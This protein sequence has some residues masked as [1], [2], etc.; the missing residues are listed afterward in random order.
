MWLYNAVNVITPITDDNE[1]LY[2]RACMWLASLLNEEHSIKMKKLTSKS[3]VISEANIVSTVCNICKVLDGQIM[4]P[5]PQAFLNMYALSNTQNNVY[6][7]ARGIVKLS[8]LFNVTYCYYP[9]RIAEAGLYLA[10]L[11]LHCEPTNN[12]RNLALLLHKNIV[13][14]EDNVYLDEILAAV[15]DIG[16]IRLIEPIPNWGLPPFDTVYRSGLHS[17]SLS[18]LE[19]I[20]SD[21]VTIGNGCYGSVYK[22]KHLDRV[23]AIK[24]HVD[25]FN[26]AIV[27]LAAMRS[28][29]SPHIESVSNFHFENTTVYTEMELRKCTLKDLIYG[30]GNVCH[31]SRYKTVWIDRRNCKVP[32]LLPKKRRRNIASQLLHGLAHLKEHGVIHRDIKP[33]NILVTSTGQIKIADF[34]LSSLHCNTI[35]KYLCPHSA[36][37]LWWRDIRLLLDY[38]YSF[39]ADMWALGIVLL[40]METGANPLAGTTTAE[41]AVDRIEGLFG[42]Y[43]TTYLVTK[44]VEFIPDRKFAVLC[45]RMMH[46]SLVDRITPSTAIEE[47]V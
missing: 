29:S 42:T 19:T 26:V 33:N 45:K 1:T 44:G 9:F 22:V 31:Y 12:E 23:V 30:I 27:E 11:V 2:I 41:E 47:L 32:K 24:E 43:G 25:Q 38:S 7:L 35:G 37:A 28:L 21:K 17:A 46:Y 14:L 4:Y 5:S 18:N 36:Y 20:L 16:K 40:E 8:T 10:S 34:G 6:L 15:P 39:E 13:D 3:L